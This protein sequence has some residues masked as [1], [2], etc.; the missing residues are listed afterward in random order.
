MKRTALNALID[1]LA[2]VALVFIASTGFLMRYQLPPGSGGFPKEY[3]L[4]Q[5][6]LPTDA[7]SDER[8][9]RLMRTNDLQM[10]DLRQVIAKYKE[11]P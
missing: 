4:D 1:T 6:G 9:G 2:F 10:Q 5:L 7:A 3:L 8:I 11:T